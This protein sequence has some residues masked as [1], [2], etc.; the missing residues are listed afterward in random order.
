MKKLFTLVVFLMAFVS[1]IKA[2]RYIYFDKLSFVAGVDNEIASS[3]GHWHFNGQQIKCVWDWGPMDIPNSDYI[4]TAVAYGDVKLISNGSQVTT[5]TRN[6]NNNN[7]F[8]FDFTNA[9]GAIVVTAVGTQGEANGYWAHYVITVPYPGE[10]VW[11]FYDQEN[12][13]APVIVENDHQSWDLNQQKINSSNGTKYPISVAAPGNYSQD[14]CYQI[15]GTNAYYIPSTAGLIFNTADKRFGICTGGSDNHVITWGGNGSVLKIPQVP[16]GYYIKIWWDAKQEGNYG[17]NFTAKN[18]QDLDGVDMTNQSFKISGIY[19]NSLGTELKGVVIFKVKNGNNGKN[20]VSFTL[21]DDGWNDLYKIEITKDYSTD[22]RLFQSKDPV[23]GWLTGGVVDY[24]SEFASIVHKKG[25][26]TERYYGGTPQASVLQRARSCDFEAEGYN[27]VSFTQTVEESTGRVPY[28]Y[29]HLSSITGTG[30]IRVIQKEKFNGFVLNKK[31]TWIAVGEYTQQTYP[32]TWDFTDYNVKKGS[33]EDGLKRSPSSNYGY[34]GQ[35][36]NTNGN[37]VYGLDTHVLVDATKG[38][39]NF[40]WNNVQIEKPLFAQGSQLTYG[41]LNGSVETILET[42]GLRVKQCNDSESELGVGGSYD[43]ELRFNINSNGGGLRFASNAHMNHKL[44]ITIP[45]VTA[46]MWVFVKADRKPEE[47][48]VGTNTLSV[49]TKS[50]NTPDTYNTQDDVW[51]YQVT[52]TGDVDIC[53]QGEA[54]VDIKAIGVTDIFKSINLLGYASESRNHAI[55]HTYEG[56]F[57]KNEVNAYCIYVDVDG[58]PYNYKGIP[59][60]MMSESYE[61]NYVPRNTGVVLFKSGHDKTKGG[62]DV[63]LFYPACNVK[64]QSGEVAAF[65]A[66]WMAPWVDEEDHDSEEVYRLTALNKYGDHEIDY[67]PDNT[68]NNPLCTK[69]VMSRKYYV[70]NKTYNSNSGIQTDREQELEAFYRMRIS[71]DVNGTSNTMAANRAYLL[72]PTAK[73]PLALWNP[74]SNG[75]GKPGLA[76]SGVIFMDDIMDLFSED[77]PSG[78]ATAID[79]AIESAETVDNGN[80]YYTLSGMKIQ[81]R[82]TEKGV[83]IMNGKKVLVK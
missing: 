49:D 12:N 10:H 53:Y 41:V 67:G 7:L 47:V 23:T 44:Y 77:E 5:I 45:N 73:L 18:V 43:H 65:K 9:G 25:Q 71:T 2:D 70:Y 68:T 83:Y 61:V 78:I 21:T 54:R 4:W 64:I 69:F 19:P 31:E 62:F 75:E 60:V 40:E 1:N 58:S 38:N 46:G 48:K 57:T 80:T 13:V 66:N 52:N 39:N 3:N 42:E 16:N 50:G 32:Y 22:M 63:P 51:A 15:D 17:A 11:N 33:L 34:W 20:D 76:K 55:D 29:L 37:K 35:V 26:T 8:S 27:G 74:K 6:D 24:N 56:F 28:N 81:G 59:I 30:N 82:P 14:N 72:I 79:D 36:D